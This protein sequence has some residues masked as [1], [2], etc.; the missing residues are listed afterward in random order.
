MEYLLDTNWVAEY[1]RGRAAVVRAI[2]DR[3]GAGLA[4]SV[5]TL[6]EVFSGI[7]RAL[8]ASGTHIGDLDLFIAA[9]TLAHGLTL[10]TQNRKHFERIIGLKLLSV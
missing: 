6:A 1:L 4:I 9:T 2:D 10:C 3:R 7:T 8:S 5:V